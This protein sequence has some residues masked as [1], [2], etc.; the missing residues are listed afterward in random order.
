MARFLDNR[1]S[2]TRTVTVNGRE[3]RWP[4]APTVVICCDGSEPAYI[5]EAT[6]RGLMPSLERIMAAGKSLIASSVIPS[7]TNP[8]N[9]SIVTGRPPAV[10]GI[11][12]NYFFDR[13]A[14]EEVMMN[15][16]LFLRARTIFEAFQ[17]AGARRKI[18]SF[19]ITSSP[20]S[21]SKK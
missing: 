3:Y 6:A 20:V 10:H 19:I 14:G 4:Q 8:N 15:D 13:D 9:L 12:G 5:E 17:Q 2:N 7:F 16:P 21:R 18:G 1:M 11:C